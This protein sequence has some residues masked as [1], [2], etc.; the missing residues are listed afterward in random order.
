MRHRS[1]AHSLGIRKIQS[2]FKSFHDHID[3]EPYLPNHELEIRLDVE[4]YSQYFAVLLRV[5]TENVVTDRHT[6]THS[7]NKRSNPRCAC[8]LRV[9]YTVRYGRRTHIVQATK[10]KLLSSH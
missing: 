9:N 1:L 6:Q 8:G 2:R 4:H 7:Q 5:Q 10:R 3:K